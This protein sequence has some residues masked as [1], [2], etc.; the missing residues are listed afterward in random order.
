M[1]RQAIAIEDLVLPPFAQ[2]DKKWF[3]LTA[4][5]NKPG[6]FNSMTVSWG[7]LGFI[8]SRPLA[9]VVVRP[10]R[11]TYQFT[12]RCDTFSLCAFPEQYREALNVLGTRSGRD[13]RKMTDCGLKPIKLSRIAS[14]GFDE[15]ELIIECR[16]SYF[17]DLD[18]KHFLA[19]HIAPNYQGDYHRMYF[20]EVVAVSGTKEYVRK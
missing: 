11:F 8:W 10:Q 20:G 13:G 5:E 4:G 1:S 15:A 19:E 6:A 3:L 2:W 17:N 7:G 14:P 9:I 16:K 18:P 12:E